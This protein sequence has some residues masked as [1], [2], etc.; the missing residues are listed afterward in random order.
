[1]DVDQDIASDTTVSLFHG[2]KNKKL[3]VSAV[4]VRVWESDFDSFL[5]GEHQHSHEDGAEAGD[6]AHTQAHRGGQEVAHPG[7]PLSGC[8]CIS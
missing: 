3:R 7:T 4:C 5:P 6:G 1:M 8:Q 2:Y